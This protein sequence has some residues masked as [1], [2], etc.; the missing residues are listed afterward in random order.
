MDCNCNPYLTAEE[1]RPGCEDLVTARIE[2]PGARRN[3]VWQTR[4]APP[5]DYENMLADALVSCFEAGMEDEDSLIRRLNEMG[6]RTPDGEEW[7]TARFESVM[8]VLGA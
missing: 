3:I 2:R 8:A 1:S 4:A 6:I 7:T 5:T